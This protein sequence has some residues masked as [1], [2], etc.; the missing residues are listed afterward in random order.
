MP[1]QKQ[2]SPEITAALEALRIH[3]EA[4]TASASDT[5][6][7]KKL[8][9]GLAVHMAKAGAEVTTDIILDE[10]KKGP[11]HIKA[12]LAAYYRPKKRRK[13]SY[14][15][16]ISDLPDP[17]LSIDAMLKEAARDGDMKRVRYLVEEKSADIHADDDAALHYAAVNGQAD[18]VR[19]LVEQGAD[20]H[21]DDDAV[22][23]SAAASRHY[24]ICHVLIEYGANKAML[25]QALPE[26][27]MYCEWKKLL[28]DLKI[29]R[30]MYLLSPHYYKPKAFKAVKEMMETEGYAESAAIYSYHIAGLFGSEDRVLQYLEK[31][32]RPGYA[33]VAQRGRQG[34]VLCADH[35][36]DN[37]SC[38]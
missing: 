4:G 27:E 30:E 3:G 19:Y 31:W 12:R 5:A 36:G 32:G 13:R 15:A 22:L 11:A 16:V 34:L 18:I 14:K 10:I 1:G 20:I 29:Q 37:A 6:D 35:G 26:Y 9:P 17:E 33:P 23:C 25:M 28:P 7:L 8:V 38:V 2:K 24:D 21:A